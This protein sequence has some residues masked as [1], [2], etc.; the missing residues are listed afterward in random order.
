VKIHGAKFGKVFRRNK[1]GNLVWEATSENPLKVASAEKRTREAPNGF[2]VQL[3]EKL[4]F[5]DSYERIPL[6]LESYFAA[7]CYRGGRRVWFRHLGEEWTACDN[8]CIYR[9]VLVQILTEASRAM[10]SEMMDERERA[11]WREL[12]RRVTVYRGCGW[13][14]RLGL[15]WTTTRAIAA[16]FPFMHR[17][18]VRAP[19]LLTACVPRSSVVAVKL[20]REEEELVVLVPEQRIVAEERLKTAVASRHE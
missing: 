20:D 19:L 3:S 11:R 5:A 2:E 4:R 13:H 12:P 8:I 16:R 10:R 9:D 7:H 15:S 17:Y 1:S 14:N 18:R 6:L